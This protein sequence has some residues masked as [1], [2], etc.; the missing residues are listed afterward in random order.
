MDVGAVLKNFLSEEGRTTT[1]RI[2]LKQK[3]NRRS[4]IFLRPVTQLR[5][6]KEK[7][8]FMR[9]LIES[10]AYMLKSNIEVFKKSGVI[11]YGKTKKEK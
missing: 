10:I 9:A 11:C 5:V 8:H 7:A 3:I 2:E 1:Q 4:E 6:K